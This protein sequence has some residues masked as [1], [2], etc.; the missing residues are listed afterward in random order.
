[1]R[2]DESD[3]SLVLAAQKGDR[4][5]FTALYLR[6]QAMLRA[7]CVRT[8]ADAML[9][10]DAMQEAAVVAML[11]LDQIRDAKQFGP[12]LCGIGLNT[13]RRFLRERNR[14]PNIDWSWDVL[15][16]G[17][18]LPEP[19]ASDMDPQEIA[20]AAELVARLRFAVAGL[21]RGQRASI[22]LFYLSGLTYSETNSAKHEPEVSLFA[23]GTQGAREIVA[24]VE[25]HWQGPGALSR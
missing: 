8:L 19:V 1:M 12:W 2:A 9:A 15:C 16:G 11:N 20:E 17:R 3:A 22:L 18:W 5:A 25:A 10:E 24:D 23:K 21:P 13:R 7:L 4:D 14:S 6:H